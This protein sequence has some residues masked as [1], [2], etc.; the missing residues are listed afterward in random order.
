MNNN[1][2]NSKR[3]QRRKKETWNTIRLYAILAIAI[4]AVVSV[5]YKTCKKQAGDERDGQLAGTAELHDLAIVS[6]PGISD[7]RMLHYPGFDV[8]FSPSDH[9]PYYAAWI[10]TPENVRAIKTNRSNNFRPDPDVPESATLADYK[11]SGYDRG[12]IAPAADM[13]YSTESQEAC[14]FLTNI[15]PQHNTLNSKAWANLET[16]CRN[17]TERDSTLVIIAGPILSDHL[18]ETIGDTRVTVPDRYFKVILAPYANPPRA[19]GFIM[20]NSYVQGGVQASAMSVDRVEEITG[21]DFFSALPDE[22]E[23]KIEAEARYSLWQNSNRKSN[24]KK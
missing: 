7:G 2:Y 12:H 11:H 9:Q 10:L 13:R 24:R 4:I 17:W 18:T 21:F 16:Q 3:R 22:L 1:Y 5:A 15:S 20:P 19:I 8:Y 23:D 6:T 14:F